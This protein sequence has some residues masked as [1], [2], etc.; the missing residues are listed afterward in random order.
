MNELVVF[1]VSVTN[2]VKTWKDNVS[3]RV[4]R[5]YVDV[6]VND[7]Y[8]S[9]T[10]YGSVGYDFGLFGQGVKYKNATSLMYEMGLMIGVDSAHVTSAR[11]FEFYTDPLMTIASPGESDFDVVG[12]FN[13]QS[14][15]LSSLKIGVTQKTMAWNAPGHSKYVIIEYCI[16]N[17]GAD[18]IKNAYVGLYS[19]FDIIDGKKNKAAYVPGKKLAYGYKEGGV[20]AGVQLLTN[21]KAN[22][23]AFN[24]NGADGSIN[25]LDGFSSK[26]QFQA[27]SSGTVR[28]SAQEGD[29]AGLIS[30]GPFNIAKGDSEWV[31]FAIMGGDNLNDLISSANNASS[32]YKELRSVQTALLEFS[33]VSCYGA[34]D[35]KISMDAFHGVKPYTFSWSNTNGINSSAATKLAGGTY[36]FKVKDKMKFELTQTFTISEPTKLQLTKGAVTDVKCYGENTGSVALSVSGGTPNYYYNWHNS[37]IPS[38]AAPNLTA[39]THILTISDSRACALTDT[40][41][42]KQPAARLL[43]SVAEI[44]NDTTGAGLGA[45]TI[46]VTGGTAPFTY[47][48][49]DALTQHTASVN[50]LSAKTY[51]A[52]ITDSHNCSASQEVVITG[53]TD[54]H[55]NAIEENDPTRYKMSVFPNP[56]TSYFFIEFELEESGIIELAL[57]DETGKKAKQVLNGIYAK[58]SYKTLVYSDDLSAGYYFYKLKTSDASA[59]GKVNVLK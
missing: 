50:N 51:N 8:T 11:D 4:N 10:N 18:A 17:Q 15:G 41:V 23:Y 19:D 28:S 20:Y 14:A 56:A 29:V 3:I 52:I 54:T 36:V 2:G 25:V 32:K 9:V 33:D 16:K 53:V 34:A 55:K 43:S 35:G 44:V 21:E 6:S 42:I 58:G 26:E 30:A 49:D 47:V 12:T 5:D 39:G 24:T 1:E 40:I 37:S 31:A 7:L 27:L 46:A 38:I 45:A 59:A 57:Y 22:Y 48:W 13:D